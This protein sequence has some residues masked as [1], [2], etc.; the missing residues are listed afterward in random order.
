MPTLLEK[1]TRRQSR[2]SIRHSAHQI[3]NLGFAETTPFHFALNDWYV[4]EK[5]QFESI[6]ARH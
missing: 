6:A 5:E 3:A 4:F 2:T 1:C